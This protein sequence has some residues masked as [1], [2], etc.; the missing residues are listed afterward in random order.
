MARSGALYEPS[1]AIQRKLG[2][3]N[4]PTLVETAR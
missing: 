1:K 4:A 3:R 2:C